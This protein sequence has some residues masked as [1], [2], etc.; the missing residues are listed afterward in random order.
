[1]T[2]LDLLEFVGEP[3]E[4]AVR[5]GFIAGERWKGADGVA[6]GTALS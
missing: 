5:A 3:A 6:A 1:M 2:T 4:A